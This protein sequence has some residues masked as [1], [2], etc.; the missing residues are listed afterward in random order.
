MVISQQSQS[1]I[2][3]SWK[4]LQ[5][6]RHSENKIQDIANKLNPQIRG[7]INYYGKINL[8]ALRSLFRQL[9]FRL[10]KWVLNKYKLRSFKE[11]Y[12]WL[13]KIQNSYPNMFYHWNYFKTV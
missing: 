3:N 13:T 12:K 10:C 8:L 11:G 7:V 9:K 1:R 2:S 4:K 5:I 6:H